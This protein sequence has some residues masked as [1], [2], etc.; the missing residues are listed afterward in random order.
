MAMVAPP[1]GEVAVS[2]FGP[3]RSPL[4]RPSSCPLGRTANESVTLAPL[5]VTW[6]SDGLTPAA[7]S[8]R[9]SALS[10]ETR[11]ARFDRTSIDIVDPAG[12]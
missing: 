6:T 11:S 4:T 10:E 8:T 2:V 7:G 3:V 9:T 1:L 12:A 5:R